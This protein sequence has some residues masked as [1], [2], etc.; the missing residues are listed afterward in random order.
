M[1]KWEKLNSVKL[2]TFSAASHQVSNRGFIKLICYSECNFAESD[3]VFV[4]AVTKEK[5][6]VC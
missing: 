4:V 2:L 1:Q 6:K 3:D 5:I